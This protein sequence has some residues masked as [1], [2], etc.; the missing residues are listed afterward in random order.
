MGWRDIFRRK[1]PRPVPGNPG[2]PPPDAS[3]IL[4]G[5]HPGNNG[6]GQDVRRPAR[7][8]CVSLSVQ[9]RSKRVG[10][11]RPGRV[12]DLSFVRYGREWWLAESSTG[13]LVN[14]GSHA[15]KRCGI[16]SVRVRGDR[17]APG[18]LR[19]GPVDLVREP[20]NEFDPNAIANYQD[21]VHCGYWNKGAARQL[22][23]VL[24]TGEHL[25]AYGISH[26]PPKVIAG[27]ATVIASLVRTMRRRAR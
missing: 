25:T 6:A 4:S 17:Y 13:R 23:K 2:V 21:G 12:A 15:L 20:F 24:D 8:I 27:D 19:V 22:A 14:V 11:G 3:H 5:S 1:P 26:D 18:T 10:S 9:R 7:R 16:W